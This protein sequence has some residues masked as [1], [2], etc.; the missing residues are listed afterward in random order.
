MTTQI[1]LRS[2][3]EQ[4]FASVLA[5]VQQSGLPEPF[6][7]SVEM[8][9]AELRPVPPADQYAELV[10]HIRH[11]SAITAELATMQAEFNEE[12]LATMT[13]KLSEYSALTTAQAEHVAQARAILENHPE[14][15]PDGKRELGTPFGTAKFRSGSKLEIESEP[16]TI[17]LIGANPKLDAAVYVHTEVS[18]DKEALEK[19][20][21]ETLKTLGVVKTPSESFSIMPAGVKIDKAAKA[22][23]AK[24]KKGAKESEVSA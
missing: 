15:L 3:A 1:D 18:V 13:A 10:S 8:R 2:P 9:L 5:A 14:W 22:A 7:T 17:R 24:A 12:L 19:L 11:Y 4:L 6:A 16:E 21:V 20:D 23:S